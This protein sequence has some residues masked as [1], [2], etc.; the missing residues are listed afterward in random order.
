VLGPADIDLVVFFAFFLTRASL[1]YCY[2]LILASAPAVRHLAIFGK[3]VSGQ[4]F[5]HIWGIC[6]TAH[7]L[8]TA[9]T[10]E[11]SFQLLSVE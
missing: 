2:S 1:S 10:N 11:T 6:M 9:K 3:S 7:L 5:G 8:F 4:I